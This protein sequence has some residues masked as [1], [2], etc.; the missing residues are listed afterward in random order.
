MFALWIYFFDLGEEQ[1]ERI[2]IYN[3]YLPNFMGNTTISILVSILF[4]AAAIV[5]SNVSLK[6]SNRIFSA[7]NILIL[8][9]AS[10]VFTLNVWSM[11]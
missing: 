5:L 10:F 4:G 1:S 2:E 8:I 3:S 7:V 11:M 6:Y 9:V